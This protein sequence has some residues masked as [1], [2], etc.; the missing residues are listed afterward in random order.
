MINVDKNPGVKLVT[1]PVAPKPR[2]KLARDLEP[3]DVIPVGWAVYGTVGM[4]VQDASLRPL[5]A[6]DPSSM[7]VDLSVRAN[8]WTAYIVRGADEELNLLSP[9]QEGQQV[10]R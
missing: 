5:R 10:E 2:T 6:G 4:Y 7:L 8:D 3:G 1:D 9:D